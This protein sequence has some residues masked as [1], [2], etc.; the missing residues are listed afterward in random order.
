M[1]HAAAP[2]EMPQ[3]AAAPGLPATTPAPG[4][5]ATTPAPGLP[6]T[7][8]APGLPDDANPDLLARIPLTARVVWDIG[9]GTGKLGMLYKRYNPQARV[10]GIEADPARARVAATRLDEVVVGDVETLAN[11]FARH[12]P[13]DCIVYGDVLEHL[14][15]PEA[16]L[17]AHARL[18]APD[19]LILICVPNVEHWS[20]AARLLAGSWAYE[21]SGLLDRTHLRWFTASGMAQA[22]REAGLSAVDM[23]PRVFQSDSH[24]AF[25]RALAPALAALGTDAA[26]YERRSAPLQFV[27]RARRT[28][29]AR[30]LHVSAHMLPPE[31]GVSH[32]RVVY[33]M[34]AIA[35]DPAIVL[36]LMRDRE[37]PELPEEAPGILVLHRLVICGSEGLASLR[38]LLGR[39]YV[40][41]MEFDDNPDFMR[42]LQ[43]PELYTFRG[44]HAVQASTPALAEVIRRDNT[45]VAVFPNAVPV[46]PQPR[47]FAGTTTTLFFGSFNRQKD[48]AA[49]MPAL[50]A[51]AALVG[52][53]LHFRI[54]HDE[55]FFNALETPHKQF[56][57]TCDHAT[58]L[59]LLGQCELVFMPLLDTPFNRCK[60]DLKFLEAAAARACALASPVVYGESIA[61]MSTGVLFQTPEELRQRLLRLVLDPAQ[62]R[63]IGEAARAHV[64]RHR[65]LAY[66]VSE[67]VA[68][69]RDLW[70]RRQALTAALR[71]R[72]P[73]LAEG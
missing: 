72:V 40:L 39:G 30:R 25:V 69:Y 56:T 73:A 6:A 55:A 2:R 52:E 58:Y 17:A 63:R 64:A 14:R 51:A 23:A 34:Q 8:P 67:R 53:R 1:S 36:H 33:P 62:A 43:Q 21:D 37:L 44:V 18:L 29:L 31:G 68:W 47:N 32:V 27:W 13:P 24:G 60:S 49:F 7:T 65:M 42:L 70:Q 57:P 59:D 71:T 3:D 41:V 15:A 10:L 54:V 45:E 26:E 50:N 46:L 66:Q 5:P 61:D 9:C 12:G 4:L 38:N 19:G 28:A 11:P 48:W 22:L 20:F 35:S 16:V